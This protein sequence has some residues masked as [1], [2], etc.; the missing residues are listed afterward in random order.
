MDTVVL[1]HKESEQF[2]RTMPQKHFF[3]CILMLTIFPMWVARVVK[4]ED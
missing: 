3:F 1:A 2:P 4:R